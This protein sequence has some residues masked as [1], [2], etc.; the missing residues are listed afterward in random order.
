MDNIETP[1]T[2]E[3]FPSTTTSLQ[4]AKTPSA[5]ASTRPPQFCP[6]CTAQFR[7]RQEL[8]RHILSRHLPWWLHCPHPACPWRGYRTQDLH[9]HLAIGRCGGVNPGWR[10]EECKTYDTKLV[11][12][13]ILEGSTTVDVAAEYA[14][15]LVGERA[16]ELGKIEMW[17]GEP[18]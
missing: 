1:F 9:N 2:P 16:R 14:H 10:P 12:G 13:W 17:G 8:E 18:P 11:V 5:S 4:G 3:D 15:D 6:K 7:R